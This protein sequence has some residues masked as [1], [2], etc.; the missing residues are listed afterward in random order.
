MQ[1]RR[2]E[3]LSAARQ[4][5]LEK[6][7]ARATVRDIAARAGCSTGA[8]TNHFPSRA[9]IVGTLAGRGREARHSLLRSIAS[10]PDPLAG[11]ADAVSGM[12][13]GPD[14]TQ[15]AALELE[16]LVE[17]RTEPDVG[18]IV[19]A[20]A[21]DALTALCELLESTG[22]DA[23]T[24]VDRARRLLAAYYGLSAL[25]ALGV[26]VSREAA[27]RWLGEILEV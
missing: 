26:P 6:G 14:S 20:G 22:L 23:G 11:L 15:L 7:F 3:L 19:G 4:V 18:A 17:G 2:E 1:E 25:A 16:V 27:R 24:S 5:V 21:Q 12:L 9:D 8:L 13:T 10:G